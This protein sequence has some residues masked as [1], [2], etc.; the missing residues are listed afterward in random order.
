MVLRGEMMVL[1]ERG[2][3]SEGELQMLTYAV[4]R[5]CVVPCR[6][7]YEAAH[8]FVPHAEATQGIGRAKNLT[9]GNA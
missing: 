9:R 1:K 3:G 2:D 4:C 5:E 7:E 8:P 6:E